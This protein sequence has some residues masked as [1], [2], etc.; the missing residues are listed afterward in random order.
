MTKPETD[1]A[2][3][4]RSLLSGMGA[5]LALAFGAAAHAAR[6][7]ADPAIESEKE[8]IVTDFCKAW[9]MRDADA[10]APY[11]A[12]DI[13]YYMFEGRPPINGLAEFS[14]QLKPFMASM[15]EIDWEPIHGR[16]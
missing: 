11:L 7:E 5:G 1:N 14:S 10:L 12:E 2:L 3:E 16:P 6:P 9:A 15:R 13:E 8:K 4:R